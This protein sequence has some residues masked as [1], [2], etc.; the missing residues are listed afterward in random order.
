MKDREEKIRKYAR[1]LIF[2]AWVRSGRPIEDGNVTFSKDDV[3]EI[4]NDIH[5]GFDGWP[6]AQQRWV[7]QEIDKVFNMT[8]AFFEMQL[9]ADNTKE[10]TYEL[11]DD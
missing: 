6:F 1:E 9:M 7:Y 4:L 3:D 10:K 2:R 11:S 5:H 8:P